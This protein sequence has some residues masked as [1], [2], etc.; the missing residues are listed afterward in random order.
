MTSMADFLIV[1]VANPFINLCNVRKG[2]DLK[3]C[4]LFFNKF[5]SGYHTCLFFLNVFIMGTI[6]KACSEEVLTLWSEGVLYIFNDA[7][8]TSTAHVVLMK[9]VALMPTYYCVI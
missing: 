9:W 3:S 4:L 2:K 8:Q 6:S 5:P 1:V 7:V